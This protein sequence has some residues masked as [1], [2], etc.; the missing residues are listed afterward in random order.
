MKKLKKPL[1]F[2]FAI[3]PFAVIGAIFTCMYQFDLYPAE[4]LEDVIAQVGSKETMI[5]ISVIQTVVYALIFGFFG[6]ILADKTGLLKPFHFEKKQVTASIVISVVSGVLFSLD[7]WTFGYAEPMIKESTIEAL[8]PSGIIAS[9]LYGGVVEEVMMRLFFLSLIA[10]VIWKLFFRKIDKEN[11]PTGV[12]IVANI[13]AAIMFAAG[14]LPATVM[15]FGGLSSLILFRCFLLNGGFGLVFGYLY[16]KH[17]IQYSM[18]CHAL[19]HIVSKLIW[20]IFI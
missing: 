18:L 11:I 4:I 8:S 9:I 2:S 13:I 15:T 7:Y 6:Y 12:F 3:L 16:R 1:L 10:F 17:G 5:A 14:H 20:V 19:V